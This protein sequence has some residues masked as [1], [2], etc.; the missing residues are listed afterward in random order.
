MKVEA[1]AAMKVA[2]RLVIL[3]S[4]RP[5]I[6]NAAQANLVILPLLLLNVSFVDV[7]FK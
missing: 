4:P 2:T 6:G 3:L 7:S 5:K 1:A